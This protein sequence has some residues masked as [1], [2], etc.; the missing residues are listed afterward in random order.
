MDIQQLLPSH[1]ISLH[2]VSRLK[3]YSEAGRDIAEDLLEQVDFGDSGFHFEALKEIRDNAGTSKVACSGWGWMRRWAKA[4]AK[5]E[6]ISSLVADVEQSV[7]SRVLEKFSFM[8]GISTEQWSADAASS[9]S[10]YEI[11]VL[12][13]AEAWR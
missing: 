6:L 2:H 4:N 5:I 10:T 9:R 1:A 3:L 12:R 7:T 11:D 13:S 8:I